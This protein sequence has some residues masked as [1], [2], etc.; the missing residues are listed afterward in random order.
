MATRPGD[1]NANVGVNI[2]EQGMAGALKSL[3]AQLTGVIKQ[4]ND[5]GKASEKVINNQIKALGQI[6]KNQS[7][8]RNYNVNQTFGGINDANRIGKMASSWDAFFRGLERGS[9]TLQKLQS[10][11]TML[12]MEAATLLQGGQ[13]VPRN[14]WD[15]R[16][17]VQEALDAFKKI[18]QAQDRF[19]RSMSDLSPQSQARLA[20][21]VSA[22]QLE[23]QRFDRLAGNSRAGPALAASI[24]AQQTITREIEAQVRILKQEEA[25]QGRLLDQTRRRAE[26]LLSMTAAERESQLRSGANRYQTLLAGRTGGGQ[27]ND[28][29]GDPARSLRR[30]T[31]GQEALLRTTTRLTQIQTQLNA[32][33]S[34]NAPQERIQQLIGRYETM[35]RLQQQSLAVTERQNQPG[36]FRGMLQ[37]AQSVAHTTG[38][39]GVASL[40][41]IGNL[42]GRVGAF[43]LAYKAI[44]LVTSALSAGA[45]FAVQFQDR[46]AGLQAISGATEGEMTRLSGAILDVA[47]N[48]NRSVIELTEA[49]TTIAQAGF[50]AAETGDLLRNTSALAAATGA[51]MAD[52]AD[53][54]TSSMGAFNLQVSE[55]TN[56]NDALVRVL[57]ESK[58][59]V[60]TMRLGIQYMGATARQQNVDINTMAAGLGAMADAGVRGS[61]AATGMRQMFIDLIDPS[62]KMA[63]HLK[64]IGLNVGDVDIKTKG[65]IPVL[66]TL[67]ENGFDAF[68]TMETRAAAAFE[69]LANNIPEIER[70]RAASFESGAAAQAE[71]ERLDTLATSWTQ[72]TNAL[73]ETASGVGTVLLPVLKV[74]LDTLTTMIDI[75]NG[76]IGALV[77][78]AVEITGLEGL[79]GGLSSEV[80]RNTTAMNEAAAQTSTTK[81]TIQA[82][83]DEISNIVGR[84]DVLS[85]STSETG[86]ETERLSQRFP[87]LRSQ[88]DGT[89]TTTNGLI[90]ALWR[91]DAQQRQTLVGNIST[92]LS[93]TQATL[94]SE[95]RNENSLRSGMLSSYGSVPS[96]LSLNPVAGFRNFWPRA[97]AATRLL[98][99]NSASDFVKG[100]QLARD[101]VNDPSLPDGLKRQFE[102]RYLEYISSR[103]NRIRLEGTATSL[104]GNLG[105]AQASINPTVMNQRMLSVNSTA[106]LRTGLNDAEGLSIAERRDMLMPSVTAARSYIAR[107][108]QLLQTARSRGLTEIAEQLASNLVTH[109]AALAAAE[110]AMQPS[111][112]ELKDTKKTES[113]AQ[114]NA[115]NAEREREE[116]RRNRGPR[117]TEVAEALRTAYGFR[118]TDTLRSAERQREYNRQGFGRRDGAVETAPH[119]QNRA[120]DFGGEVDT[121]ENRAKIKRM[122]EEMGGANVRFNYHQGTGGRKHL[123]AEYEISTNEQAAEAREDYIQELRELAR[124]RE[125]FFK[126]QLKVLKEEEA[127]QKDQLEGAL[128]IVAEEDTLSNLAQRSAAVFQEWR[129]Y[130]E[131]ALKTARTE[132]E[133]DMLQGA[134]LDR[135]MAAANARLDE[136]YRNTVQGVAD[137]INKSITDFMKRRQALAEIAFH[138]ATLEAERNVALA[139]ATTQGLSDPLLAGRVPGYTQTLA[140]H[141]ANIA[142]RRLQESTFAANDAR[143]INARSDVQELEQALVKLSNSSEFNKD[144]WDA[145]NQQL[146]EAKANLEQLQITQD[147]LG[148]QLNA[149][150]LRPQNWGDALQQ[151]VAAWQVQNQSGIG[152]SERMWQGLGDTLDNVHSSFQ[153]FFTDILTGTKSV[154]NAFGDMAKAVAN[155]MMEMAAKAI[156]TQVFSLLLSFLPGGNGALSG[157]S[158]PAGSFYKGGLIGTSGQNIPDVFSGGMYTGGAVGKYAGGGLINKGIPTRD[159]V[160]ILASR[161]EFMMRRSAVE[162]IGHSMLM[163]M[164][165]RGAAAL[166]KVG[167]RAGAVVIP[168]TPVETNVWVVMPEEKPVPGPN[169]IIA[170]VNNDVL[171]GGPTKQLIRRVAQG[172]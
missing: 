163:D 61:T 12:N 45:T 96:L 121:P 48:S 132:A 115:R 116:A 57:N 169:D 106:S 109:R 94:G 159:T 63:K 43:T 17:H 129:E 107:Q 136:E 125:D 170:V 39:G 49:A 26:A 95:Q 1:I 117:A 83:G 76:T 131:A 65:L 123:H 164:N 87:E 147:A 13:S 37:G 2:N 142:N 47:R 111:E 7:T 38:A 55:S 74:L 9:P 155:A 154:G 97:Q 16:L 20:P 52:A 150:S 5:A 168:Q 42:I 23:Q 99:S 50:S 108:E 90:D 92:E 41:G 158:L 66:K 10:R 124:A 68:S 31:D 91:L 67:R 98:T 78:W 133:K 152:L 126:D 62:D 84:Y 100:Q 165:N 134:E 119:V 27:F 156:A 11:M 141:Q 36:F 93:K 120:L 58:L 146:L 73:G 4:I 6:Q 33:M 82:L 40:G 89:I 19:Q 71:S 70:L 104:Q 54:L 130:R 79:L 102:R 35:L 77:S 160:P 112:T 3:Q 59:S 114:R 101:I 56:V 80:D 32:A 29:I 162:D 53:I 166:D 46:L 88:M 172:G 30:H 139:N 140:Q 127:M 8:L 86:A 171:R 143:L 167:K 85:K 113:E 145:I 157:L 137:N 148:A 25:A 75:I 110:R 72:F 24:S 60:D 44:N 69:V 149:G 138:R 105:A 122:I 22:L 81:D 21:R 128:S 34:S 14:I 15:K 144:Q 151:S 64:E 118:V 153:T 161:G 103:S 18:Q 51:S 135:Y 28:V